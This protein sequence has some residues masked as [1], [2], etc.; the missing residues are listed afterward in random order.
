MLAKRLLGILPPL[1]LDEA[2]EI[3]KIHSV[4]SKIEVNSSLVIRCPFRDPHHTIT[5]IA[6][7]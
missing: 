7:N 1:S 6:I 5:D 2:L 4:A 3:T